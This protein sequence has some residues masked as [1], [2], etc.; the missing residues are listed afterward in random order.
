MNNNDNRSLQLGDTLVF[1]DTGEEDV[2]DFEERFT[3][4]PK[5]EPPGTSQP[6]IRHALDANQAD[7]LTAYSAEQGAFH[8][9]PSGLLSVVALLSTPRNVAR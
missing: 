2:W 9:V 4:E 1:E 3:Q 7:I 5:A 8:A 6:Q